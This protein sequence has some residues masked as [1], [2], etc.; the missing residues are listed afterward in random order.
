MA[1]TLQKVHKRITKKRGV[2][3]ALHENSRD[4]RLLRRAGARDD[5]LSRHAATTL[6]TRKPY[7][8]TD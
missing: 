4:A 2:V 7:C 6:K 3:D 1:R 5:R 8:E